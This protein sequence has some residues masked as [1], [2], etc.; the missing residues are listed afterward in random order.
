MTWRSNYSRLLNN[1]RINRTRRTRN[2][3]R[4]SDS[5]QDYLETIIIHSDSSDEERRLD[6]EIDQLR[7][8]MDELDEEKIRLRREMAKKYKER[9]SVR[10]ARRIKK[11]NL[12]LR[13][14][15]ENR[16]LPTVERIA[17]KRQ[18]IVY[19]IRD[20]FENIDD[21][22]SKLPPSYTSLFQSKTTSS[23]AEPSTSNNA[24]NNNNDDNA[25]NASTTSS[26]SLPS[27]NSI[28]DSIIN[29]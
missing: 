29:N 19:G 24:T 23:T 3:L 28:F 7:D 9:E 13:T 6:N 8:R 20:L 22:E 5:S 10:V 14:E 1:P 4:R 2:L 11:N 18:D 21:D 12:R 27:V 25:S 26:D 17:A 16:L 15:I